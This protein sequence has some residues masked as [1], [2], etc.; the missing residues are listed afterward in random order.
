[1]AALL[2]K[3][4]DHQKHPVLTE[5]ERIAQFG[6][7]TPTRR[8]ASLPASQRNAPMPKQAD[9]LYDNNADIQ[10]STPRITDDL[11]L[12][13]E[14]GPATGR[15]PIAINTRRSGGNTNPPRAG[16]QHITSSQQAH[17]SVWKVIFGFLSAVVTALF[18]LYTVVFLIVAGWI[19]LSNAWQ[20]GQAHA[21]S[22]QVVIDGK[23]TTII[24]SNINHTI[25]VTIISKDGPAKMYTGA[26]L[27]ASSWN[28]DPGSVVAT[29]SV[30]KGQTPTITISLVGSVNYI[31]PL[32][33]R[34]QSSFSLVPDKQAGYKVVQ[35]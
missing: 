6:T 17:R 34:P 35:S 32:F 2:E 19:A 5:E 21:A 1:M 13:E 29:A 10:T 22:T 16:G 27:D 20:Y 15:Q 30:G 33:V 25:Y 11:D 26:V 12:E 7:Y 8:R 9:H 18:I 23:P 14:E 28:N 24:T 3:V 31:R 4:R